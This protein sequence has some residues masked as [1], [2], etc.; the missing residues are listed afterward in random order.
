MRSGSCIQPT[1]TAME[2]IHIPPSNKTSV[3]TKRVSQT[4][5]TGITPY[6]R[7]SPETM[8]DHT[9]PRFGFSPG[10]PSSAGS[11]PRESFLLAPEPAAMFNTGYYDLYYEAKSKR[12][13]I[14][15][16]IENKD[17]A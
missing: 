15:V 3:I 14:P 12:K 17:E 8:I 1:T 6:H 10:S 16:P 2:R 5:E 13:P 4:F 11:S 9:P 7:A